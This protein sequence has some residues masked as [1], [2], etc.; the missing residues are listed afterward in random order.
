MSDPNFP[1]PNA[2]LIAE[3]QSA[4]N[5]LDLD[6]LD[7]DWPGVSPCPNCNHQLEL[8]ADFRCVHCGSSH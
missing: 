6:E 3:L 5:E 2:D 4:L 1:E 8:D 7:R